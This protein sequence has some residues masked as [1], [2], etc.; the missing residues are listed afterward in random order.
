MTDR[1]TKAAVNGF[2]GP[3]RLIASLLTA[4]FAVVAAFTAHQSTEK[5]A[6]QSSERGSQRGG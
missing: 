5:V 2:K 3:F 4:I 6:P 1:L